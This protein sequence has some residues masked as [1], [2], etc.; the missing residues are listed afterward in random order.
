MQT[1]FGFPG[2]AGSRAYTP[3]ERCLPAASYANHMILPP[4]L[5]TFTVHGPPIGVVPSW[6]APVVS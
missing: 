4:S 5:D 1:Q 6:G 3:S 2:P